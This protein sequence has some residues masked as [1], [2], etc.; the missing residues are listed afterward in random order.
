MPNHFSGLL[1]CRR[2]I[3]IDIAITIHVKKN[4]VGGNIFNVTQH[5]LH[6][7]TILPHDIQ[8]PVVTRH[9]E[10]LFKKIGLVTFDFIH[11]KTLVQNRSD[12]HQTVK[13][14][15][16]Q[17]RSDVIEH[18]HDFRMLIRINANP[19]ENRQHLIPLRVCAALRFLK[20]QL[21]TSPMFQPKQIRFRTKQAPLSIFGDDF[22]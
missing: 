11:L 2:H 7:L 21:S 13:T 6:P 10:F 9:L 12:R 18:C 1:D 4:S 5:F 15:T 17:Q 16:F 22:F 20:E 19:G 8:T 3:G 14:F